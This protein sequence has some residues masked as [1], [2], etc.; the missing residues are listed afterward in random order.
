M[1]RLLL[2]L[3]YLFRLVALLAQHMQSSDT[4]VFWENIALILRI[5]AGIRRELLQEKVELLTA[6]I[7]HWQFLHSPKCK[8]DGLLAAT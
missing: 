4:A 6:C 5:S 7:L 3:L 2:S 8:V 1:W